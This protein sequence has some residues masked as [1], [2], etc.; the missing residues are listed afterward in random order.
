MNLQIDIDSL[1]KLEIKPNV[2]FDLGT[3]N[4]TSV[5]DFRDDSFAS[6]LLTNINNTYD[7]KGVS[8]NSEA[9]LRRKFAKKDRELEAKYILRYNDNSSEGK[10]VTNTNAL[11]FD[12]VVNQRKTNNNFGNTNYITLS[13][14]EPLSKSFLLTTEYFLEL[15]A[16][17]KRATPTIQ[18]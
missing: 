16:L 6:Y 7:S 1:T 3:Q 5:N 8:S 13:Y 18:T 14:T 4:N 12:T 11:V 2:H 17:T 15:G 10:L 9:I